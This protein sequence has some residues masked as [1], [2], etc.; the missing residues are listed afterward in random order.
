MFD[1]DFSILQVHQFFH[2]LTGVC[3]L[4]DVIKRRSRYVTLPWYSKIFWWQQTENLLKKRIRTVLNFID[5]I[6][7]HLISQ[8]VAK[9]SGVKS[10]RT[11]SKS[12]LKKTKVFVL[13]STTPWSGCVKLGSFMS[14]SCRVMHVQSCCFANINL[15]RCASSGLGH[16]GQSYIKYYLDFYAVLVAVVV[17]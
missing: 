4:H 3:I 5:L 7:F 15:Q 12:R 2:P 1:F 14:Q 9:F 16:Y 13:Y 11:V 10:E 6:Q 8:K 17:G